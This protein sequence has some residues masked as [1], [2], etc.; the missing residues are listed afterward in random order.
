MNGILRFLKGYYTVGFS[1][2][3][4]RRILNFLLEKNIPVWNICGEE[5]KVSFCIS[6]YHYAYLSPFLKTV[7]E[8]EK[9]E[10]Q[11]GGSL[12]FFDLFRARWGFFSGFFIFCLSLL[13]ST[14]VVWGVEVVGND[15]IPTEK[16]KEDLAEYGVKP[17]AF[18]A[19]FDPKE[20]G[21]RY[22][23]T[24]TDFVYVNI[25]IIGTRACVEVRE[26]EYVDK[27][28]K[29]ES[30]SNQVAEIYGT[31][32]RY[33]VL[34]GQIQVK[35]G[36][37]VVKGQL[38]ISGVKE[39]KTGTLQ[40]LPAK[41]RVFAK[42]VRSF[43]VKIPYEEKIK[44]YTGEERE[45]ISIE[46]LGIKLSLPFGKYKENESW[47][48]SESIED[49]TFF[50]KVLPIRIHRLLFAETEEKKEAIILDRAR[51]LAYDKYNE[52]KRETFAT[53][54]E[55]LEENLSFSQ[56]K[57]GLILSAELTLLED[58]CKEVPFRVY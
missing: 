25:N 20:V 15:Q 9:L 52:F 45:K 31:I 1:S 55:I 32:M 26:R 3:N 19:S 40:I 8:D 21:M 12:R 58:I 18:L 30:P 42:T 7:K 39:N 14:T 47:Q 2:E 51:V 17:G 54:D 43:Q 53:D 10:T 11:K 56:E 38:L 27:E 48:E 36:D 29:E 41:G 6:A 37:H 35:P 33:E 16:I 57:D 13:L 49:L 5:K 50:G 28:K 24:G 46:I 23:I 22:Q 34:S 44:V 4:A